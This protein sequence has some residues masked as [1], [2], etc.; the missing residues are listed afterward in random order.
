MAQIF[1]NQCYRN[2]PCLHGTPIKVK[3]EP[4]WDYFDRQ[5]RRYIYL[6]CRLHQKYYSQSPLE[7]EIEENYQLGL[8]Q[9]Q[10]DHPDLQLHDSDGVWFTNSDNPESYQFPIASVED[11]ESNVN[12]SDDPMSCNRCDLICDIRDDGRYLEENGSCP[13]PSPGPE[14]LYSKVMDY[15]RPC[16]DFLHPL[17][18]QDIEAINRKKRR[19]VK[20]KLGFYLKQKKWRDLLINKGERIIDVWRR[21]YQP[22]SFYFRSFET[23]WLYIKNLPLEMKKNKHFLQRIRKNLEYSPSFRECFGKGEWE[24]RM[25]LMINKFAVKQEKG[26]H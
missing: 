21:N 12:Y 8:S 22:A 16:E 25:L 2:G 18:L 15:D 11:N 10:R 7:A 14:P 9:R 23:V 4:D 6:E 3:K 26:I 1:K 20:A 5:S 24:K 13:F 17:L 19:I